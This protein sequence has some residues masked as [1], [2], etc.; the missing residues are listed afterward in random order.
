MFLDYQ[1]NLCT[2]FLFIENGEVSQRTTLL[3]LKSNKRLQDF[4]GENNLKF[5][6]YLDLRKKNL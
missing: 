2:V 5:Y 4:R 6:A 1:F 3:A